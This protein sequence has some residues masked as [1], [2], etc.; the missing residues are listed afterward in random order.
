MTFDKISEKT[1]SEK[2]ISSDNDEELDR[3]FCKF[4]Q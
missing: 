4:N 2:T 3:N 1:F